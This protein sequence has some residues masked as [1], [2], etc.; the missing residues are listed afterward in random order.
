ME[1]TRRQ[2]GGVERSRGVGKAT[3]SVPDVTAHAHGIIAFMSD[4]RCPYQCW[5]LDGFKLIQCNHAIAIL[6]YLCPLPH[7][8]VT[9]TKWY[10]TRIQATHMATNQQTKQ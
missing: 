1:E 3:A 6:I 8:F 10:S 5:N 4:S 9:T 7:H 2:Q